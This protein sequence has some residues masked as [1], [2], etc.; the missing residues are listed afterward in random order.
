M[1][2]HNKYQKKKKKTDGCRKVWISH[3]HVSKHQGSL[4]RSGNSF[5]YFE[6][7]KVKVTSGT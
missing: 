6:N 5:G 2:M 4:G 1:I 7:Q 3:I